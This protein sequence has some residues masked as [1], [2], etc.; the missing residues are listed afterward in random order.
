M[1]GSRRQSSAQLTS[2]QGYVCVLGNAVVA[3]GKTQLNRDLEK[4]PA[5]ARRRQRAR[6]LG[7]M[8]WVRF[9]PRGQKIAADMEMSSP[10]MTKIEVSSV[11]PII[12]GRAD[13]SFRQNPLEHKSTNFVRNFLF[14]IIDLYLKNSH[15]NWR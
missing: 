8:N 3:L 11:K 5:D 7:Q 12:R 6:Q 13:G 10:C 15:V 14:S 2:A 9:S 1:F 4:R